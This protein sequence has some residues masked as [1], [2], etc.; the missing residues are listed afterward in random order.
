MSE[1]LVVGEA[2][3]D[4]VFG[5]I[6]RLPDRGEEV[7]ASRYELRPGG[8][9]GYASMGL[10]A[11]D[12][13][14]RLATLVGTDDLSDRWLEFVEAQGVDTTP[15]EQVPDTTVSTAAAFLFPDERSFVTYRGATGS[16]RSLTPTV[17]ACDAVLVTGFS[18]APY[19]WSDELVAFIQAL[20]EEDMPVFLDTNWSP[21][22]WQGAFEA[23]LPAVDFLL[24]NDREARRLAD[25]D[26]VPAAGS[27]LVD[28]GA[29][30][31]VIK[32]GADGC[33]IV[34]TGGV[35]TVGTEPCDAV[36]ACGAGDFFNAGFIAARLDGHAAPDA[37]VTG[38]R[39][40]RE[41]IRAFALDDK[42]TAIRAL[43]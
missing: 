13:N 3:I 31:C 12:V 2:I 6:D 24:V 27:T 20:G 32:T 30:T 42:L 28:R 26:T 29:G 36:D 5:G 17:G 21:S 40:A 11:R 41:A 18:Q 37:A 23:V 9:A 7:V 1:V 4:F 38:N 16:D 33:T 15:V 8:S 19:L 39:C 22:D 25:A 35:E 14:V 43:P 10:A 34:D